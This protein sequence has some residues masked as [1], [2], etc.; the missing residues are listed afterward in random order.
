MAK[1]VKNT[2]RMH[3]YKKGSF[4]WPQYLELRAIIERENCG[5]RRKRDGQPCEAQAMPNGRCKWHGGMSTGPRTLAG[6]CRALQNLKQ[7]CPRP[8]KLI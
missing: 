4:R 5:A 7:F 6:K 3:P 1:K 8:T 2:L